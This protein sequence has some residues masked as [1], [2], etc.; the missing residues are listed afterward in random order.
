[1]PSMLS[2]FI[3]LQPSKNSFLLSERKKISVNTSHAPSTSHLPSV[4]QSERSQQHVGAPSPTLWVT[5][6]AARTDVASGPSWP[7]RSTHTSPAGALQSPEELCNM[8]SR[9]C[10]TPTARAFHQHGVNHISHRRSAEH[11]G[12]Y[13]SCSMAPHTEQV[14]VMLP[15]PEGPCSG[16]AAHKEE[17]LSSGLPSIYGCFSRLKGRGGASCD[18]QRGYKQRDP[19]H[20][21]QATMQHTDTAQSRAPGSTPTTCHKDRWLTVISFIL[22]S[23]CCSIATSWCQ[24]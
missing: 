17:S 20:M 10:S 6:V 14:H 21:A 8:A 2:A 13:H 1:M 5:A 16:Q 4:G 18:G 22:R 9:I 11:T 7:T 15:V 24:P 19:H 23:R 3:A 12:K